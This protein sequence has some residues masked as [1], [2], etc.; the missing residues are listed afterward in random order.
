MHRRL[1]VKNSVAVQQFAAPAR[2]AI[3]VRIGRYHYRMHKIEYKSCKESII[4]APK[5][6]P[7]FKAKPFALKYLCQCL[8]RVKIEDK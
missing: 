2:L 4:F 7:N 6:I 1:W 5:A 3:L 8:N